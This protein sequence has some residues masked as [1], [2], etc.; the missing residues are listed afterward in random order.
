MKTRI[1]W[2]QTDLS[3]FRYGSDV[4]FR[5]NVIYFKNLLIPAGE[6]IHRWDSKTHYQR[7]RKQ[8]TLPLLFRNRHY[9][10]HLEAEIIP[11]DTVYLKLEFYDRSDNLIKSEILRGKTAQF[12]YPNEAYSY[13]IQLFNASVTEL[14][15][16]YIEI[17][18]IY[19]TPLVKKE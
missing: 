12:T 18:S 3:T 7:D 9:Q 16:R 1:Y 13:S 6:S 17:S 15:F 19:A 11:E 2:R 14:A 4:Q 8:P 10:L 5:N